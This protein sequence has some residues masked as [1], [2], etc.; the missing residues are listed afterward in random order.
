MSNLSIR[1]KSIN[2]WL[3]TDSVFGD[4]IISKFYFNSFFAKF[5]IVEEGNARLEQYEIANITLYDDTDGG[6]AETFTN[7]TELSLRLEEL[8]YPAFDRTGTSVFPS[9][10]Q[11]TNVNVTDVEDGQ[12]LA[13]DVATSKWLNIT[14][15]SG[16]TPTWQDVIL[17]NGVVD[18]ASGDYVTYVDFGTPGIV[19][20]QIFSEFGVTIYLMTGGGFKINCIGIDETET[21]LELNNNKIE[22]S[23]QK[24]GGITAL[25]FQDPLP[26]ITSNILIPSKDTT[27]D[28]VLATQS[29]I[30]NANTTAQNDSKYTVIANATFTDPTP[31]EGKGYTVFVRNGTATIGGV[32]YTAGSLVYRVYYSG[33]WSST[34]IGGTVPDADASTKGIAKLYTD[35]LALNTDGSVT[36]SALVTEFNLKDVLP[37]IYEKHANVPIFGSAS[38]NNLEGVT[39]AVT[40]GTART[41]SDTSIY[42]RRQRLGLVTTTTGNAAQMRQTLAYFNR[43]SNLLFIIGLGFAENC[44]NPNVRAFAGVC[45]NLGVFGN[46]EPT[47]LLN[48]IGLAKLTT[49]NNLHVI[50]NDGSGTATAIDLGVNFPSNTVETDFYILIGET[51]G[52]N[53]NYTVN[54]VNT[55]GVVTGT[56]TTDLP[57]PSTALNLGYYVVQNT[58]ANTNTGIDFFGTNLIKQ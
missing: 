25:K 58:G 54:R 7:I 48:C 51:N 53:I 4:F 57:S 36:Q 32:G 42:T 52:S 31:A 23:I 5:Q 56:I 47:A 26:S 40:G 27:G 18:I 14:I 49:S 39:F 17:Q 16:T 24:N 1:K 44:T 46:T 13:W 8:Q 34:S 38:L 35:L 3:H 22:Y 43:N 9:M 15:G 28:Y 29:E 10:E 19:E 33:A 6:V 37:V 21:I 55:G 41:F 2:T 20:F 30:I 45:A 50:H 12:V 11:I